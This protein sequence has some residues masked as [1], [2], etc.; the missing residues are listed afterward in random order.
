[1]VAVNSGSRVGWCTCCFFPVCR[2][3]GHGSVLVYLL[4]DGSQQKCIQYW[5]LIDKI[6]QQVALQTKDGNPDLAP[7]DVDVRK[8]LKQFVYISLSLFIIF[9]H[10]YEIHR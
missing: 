10:Q 4:A 9:I 3:C 6:I 8:L 5:Q 1:M 7:L 2:T